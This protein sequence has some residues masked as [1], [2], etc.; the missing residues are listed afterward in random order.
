MKLSVNPMARALIFDLDGTLSDSMAVHVAV[1]DK[2]GEELG[3]SF[4]RKM[5]WEMT[6]MPTIAFAKRVVRENHL[7]IHPDTLADLKHQTFRDF[8]HLIKPVGEVAAIMKEWHGKLPMSVGT[9]ASRESAYLQLD[10]LGFTRYFD[11]VVTA[12]DVTRHK[13]ESETFLRCAELMGVEP[14]CCQVFEDG[15]LG[16]EAARS[17]GMMLTDVRPYINYVEWKPS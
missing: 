14:A 11:F 10:R 2:L 15:R 3:F 1:W 16:M 9:G 8:V 7:G 12:D 13:P 6:G 17:A 4:D 5:V